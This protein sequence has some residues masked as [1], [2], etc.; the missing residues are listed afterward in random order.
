MYL[1]KINLSA[2]RSSSIDPIRTWEN[3]M[4]KEKEDK[5]HIY[6]RRNNP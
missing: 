5:D 2:V 6:K 1:T 4:I 3:T